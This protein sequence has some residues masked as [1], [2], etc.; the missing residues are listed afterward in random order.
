[1]D[2]GITWDEP[3]TVNAGIQTVVALSH[4]GFN[5]PAWWLNYEHPPLGKYIYG[6]CIWLFNSSNYDYNGFFIARLASA[7]MGAATCLLIYLIG[8]D[9]FNRPAGAIAAIILALIPDFVAH[10][11]IAALDSPIAFFFTLAMFLFMLAIK[12]NRP[13]YYGASAVSLGLLIDVKLN[14][15]LI[16]PVIGISYL[17]YRLTVASREDLKNSEPL[18]QRRLISTLFDRYISPGPFI[19]FCLI[20]LLTVI[21]IWPWLWTNPIQHLSLTLGHWAETHPK[22]Y[23][24]GDYIHPP[25]YY[26]LIYFAVTTPLLI[27]IPLAAGLCMAF[28]SRD[29]FKY[30]V[31]LWLIVP[32]TYSLSSFVIGGMRYLLMIYP[33]V[34]L[35]SG[36]GLYGL[37]MRIKKLG[38][39]RIIQKRAL[40]LLSIILAVYLILCLASIYPYYLDYYNSLSGGYEEVHDDHLFNFGWWG[41][42]LTEA[43]RYIEANAPAGSTVFTQTMPNNPYN[44]FMLYGNGMVYCYYDNDKAVRYYSQN[45]TFDNSINNSTDLMNSDYVIVNYYYEEYARKTIDISRFQPVYIV[46]VG[47]APIVTVYKNKLPSGAS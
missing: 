15:L 37:A 47:G 10:T 3:V 1:M 19:A 23:L 22:E 20:V 35:L 13:I 5:S 34:A 28:R 7:L 40:S 42:G 11:Q 38:V 8:R 46:K 27:F 26:Y 29:P 25:V 41:E 16:L 30:A 17:L 39:P 45:A 36:Y 31:I 43:I 4:F 21:S 6:I 9:Y 24:L 14:G 2:A 44:T 12:K 18:R 32:F 33:A